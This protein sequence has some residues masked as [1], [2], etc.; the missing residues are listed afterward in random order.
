MTPALRCVL[1]L[2][3]AIASLALATPEAAAQTS[4]DGPSQVGCQVDP[5]DGS[6]EVE[7][8]GDDGVPGSSGV[9]V[10][11]EDPC[12][13][14]P[15]LYGDTER[16]R[17]MAPDSED[18][19][20]GNGLPACV[21]DDLDGN[22][23]NEPCNAPGAPC[24]GFVVGDPDP[25]NCRPQV[26]PRPVFTP[27]TVGEAAQH[28]LDQ[29][30]WPSIDPA[31]SD[32]GEGVVYGGYEYSLALAG[33]EAWEP[34]VASATITQ[35]IVVQGFVFTEDFTA[36]LTA[37][38]REVWWDTG[39]INDTAT[40][41]SPPREVVCEGPGS[42]DWLGD[43]T[44]KNFETYNSYGGPDCLFVWWNNSASIGG[45]QFFMEAEVVWDL[46][47]ETSWAGDMG[48]VGEH[49][50][51]YTAAGLD[52]HLSYALNVSAG[53]QTTQEVNGG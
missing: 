37:T 38:P 35:T 53:S 7:A 16:C 27:P 42:P 11:D 46:T 52:A 41:H 44:F 6:V 17:A 51:V 32:F 47:L 10:T 25:D 15:E 14:Q 43:G 3:L 4:C 49:T 26:P 1:T 19:S 21:D 50:E 34:L 23:D 18:G 5:N 9:P 48:S 40:R 36:T 22:Y 45:R 28:A 29:V 2:A 39:P 24:I 30:V 12:I 8:P 13:T 31:T 33:Y 20:A